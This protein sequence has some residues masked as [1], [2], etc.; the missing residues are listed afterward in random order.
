MKHLRVKCV[1]ILPSRWEDSV[2]S[3]GMQFRLTPQLLGQIYR[4]FSV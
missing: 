3:I 1:N 4:F 2:K